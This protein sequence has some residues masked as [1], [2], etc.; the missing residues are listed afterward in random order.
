MS[1]VINIT[2]AQIESEVLHSDIPVLIDFY[3]DWCGPCKTLAPRLEA[4]AKKYAGSLKVVKIDVD[5]NR[6]AVQMFRIQSMPTLIL[7][8]DQQ[9]ADMAQGALSAE[10]LEAFVSNVVQASP[11]GV[12]NW[13]ARRLKLGIEAT[14]ATAIDVREAGDFERAH[15]P[16]AVNIPAAAL[17]ASIDA[18]RALDADVVLYDRT[19]GDLKTLAETVAAAGI[20]TGVLE[21]GF[22]GW[23][24]EMYP[25]EKGA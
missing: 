24:A 2:D 1:N 11:G 8:A 3:A 4:I 6:A 12:E 5:A 20:P 13:D 15:I 7:I 19:D 14:V 18:L 10:Q 21:G 22:L 25:V 17:A 16:G 9:I 23:E